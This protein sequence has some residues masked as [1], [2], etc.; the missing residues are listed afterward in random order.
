MEL[1]GLLAGLFFAGW[2]FMGVFP[3]TY[4]TIRAWVEKHA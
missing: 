4:E 2:I 1:I 3:K